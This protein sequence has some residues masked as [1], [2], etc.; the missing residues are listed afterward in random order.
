MQFFGSLLLRFRR[1]P[2]D[3][4]DVAIQRSLDIVDQF[5]RALFALWRERALYIGLS[6]GLAQVPIRHADTTPPAR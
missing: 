4:A 3:L 5:N 6:E 1:H 2:T